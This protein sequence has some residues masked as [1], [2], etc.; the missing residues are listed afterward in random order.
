MDLNFIFQQENKKVS[1]QNFRNLSKIYMECLNIL[2]GK[3]TRSCLFFC[4]FS[5]LYFWTK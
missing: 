3:R 1:A 2:I 5:C 4:L